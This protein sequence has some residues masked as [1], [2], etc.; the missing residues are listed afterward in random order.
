MM[1][2]RG[3]TIDTI[4]FAS[5]VA[6]CK[7]HSGLKSSPSRLLSALSNPW[8]S[9]LCTPSQQI[10]S[11]NHSTGRVTRG[12]VPIRKFRALR[13]S[14]QLI[15]PRRDCLYPLPGPSL[16]RSCAARRVCPVHSKNH[17]RWHPPWQEAENIALIEDHRGKTHTHTNRWARL[18][19]RF[20]FPIFNVT[21]RFTTATWSW[22][23]VD[24]KFWRS[25]VL[26]VVF[27]FFFFKQ[28]IC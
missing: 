26:V 19:F 24:K 28:R 17:P 8:P 4:S 10:F 16:P 1:P 12:W 22:C 11:S 5:P 7:T 6:P 18:F 23:K 21:L 25:K 27:F 9:T 14:S 20:F 13:D 2:H 15:A 3:K